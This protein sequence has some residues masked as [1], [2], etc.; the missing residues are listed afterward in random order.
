MLSFTILSDSFD[1][2]S[3]VCDHSRQC[4]ELKEFLHKAVPEA[5]VSCTTGRRGSFEVKINDIL[6]HSKLKTMAFA[7]HDDVA[8][9][10]KNFMEGKEV[11][12]VKEQKITDCCIS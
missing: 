7:D 9:N 8:L 10:I 3:A 4:N 12:T 11:K 1:C 5:E 2:F 6:V